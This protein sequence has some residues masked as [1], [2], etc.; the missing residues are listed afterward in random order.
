[1]PFLH[2][3]LHNHE[4][5]FAEELWALFDD[6]T[7]VLA[8]LRDE[9]LQLAGAL[10][11]IAVHYNGLSTTNSTLGPEVVNDTANDKGVHEFDWVLRVT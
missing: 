5:A 2:L 3:D 11:R 9:L 6:L 4:H 1:M 8:D 7:R 10:C